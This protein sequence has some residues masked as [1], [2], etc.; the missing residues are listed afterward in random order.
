VK[1]LAVA[2]FALLVLLFAGI[3][4][5]AA[6]ATVVDEDQ[7]SPEIAARKAECR[8]LVA[9]VFELSP[10]SQLQG[11]SGADRQARLDALVAKVPIEDIEQCAA[12]DKDKKTKEDR[13]P[14]A[15]A[16]M[17]AASDHAAIQACVPASQD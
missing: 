6:Y 14:A 8:K 12:A 9:H 10:D 7:D 1:S 5:V 2:A 15:V 17:K 11:L 13:K 3:L 4:T 16:C